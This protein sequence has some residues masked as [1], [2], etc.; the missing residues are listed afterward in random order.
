MAMQKKQRPAELLTLISRHARRE[1]T[2]GAGVPLLCTSKHNNPPRCF[3][4]PQAPVA[5]LPPTQSARERCEGGPLWYHLEAGCPGPLPRGKP[6]AP[7]ANPLPVWPL[8]AWRGGAARGPPPAAAPH[9]DVTAAASGAQHMPGS[10]NPV[11]CRL[12]CRLD[13]R[14]G[15]LGR[16]RRQQSAALP[17]RRPAWR[18]A[19][20]PR[21]KR[22]PQA[23][24]PTTRALQWPRVLR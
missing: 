20:G 15:R 19:A 13:C 3:P 9:T 10:C 23:S 18:P 12:G 14:L 1:G 11:G 4:S 22:A 17:A 21:S 2:E 5:A 24:T 8:P 6:Y 7:C 16:P